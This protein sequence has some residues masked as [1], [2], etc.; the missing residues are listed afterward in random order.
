MKADL[1][2]QRRTEA[3][4]KETGLSAKEAVVAYVPISSNPSLATRSS[5][6]YARI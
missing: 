5:V 3:W 6:G 4:R 1:Q 2:N